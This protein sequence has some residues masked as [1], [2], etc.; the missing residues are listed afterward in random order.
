MCTHYCVVLLCPVSLPSHSA[1]HICQLFEQRAAHAGSSGAPTFAA[2]PHEDW[3]GEG[4]ATRMDTS[5]VNTTSV[6]WRFVLKLSSGHLLAFFVQNNFGNGPLST[7]DVMKRFEA[8]R[9]DFVR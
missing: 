1:S 2:A 9:A 5:T 6:D 7:K 8:L 3:L 4:Y